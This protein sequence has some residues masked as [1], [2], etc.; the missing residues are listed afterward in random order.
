[1]LVCA[2]AADAD[3]VAVGIQCCT[4]ASYTIYKR[5]IHKTHAYYDRSAQRDIHA[6]YSK[7]SYVEMG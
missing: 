5:Y 1:M 2:T 4:C 3:A 6:K 7:Q